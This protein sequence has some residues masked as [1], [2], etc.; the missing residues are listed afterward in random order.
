MATD[1]QQKLLNAITQA[2]GQLYLVGGAVRDQLLG[3]V[4]KDND[5][6]VTGLNIETVQNTLANFARVDAV[7]KSFGVLKVTLNDETVDVALPRT[8]QSTGLHHRDFDITSDAHLPIEADL[9]RR[10]FT[11]NAMALR[12]H[13]QVLIDPFFGKRDLQLRTLRAVGNVVQRFS[14]DPLRMLR[15]ARFVAKLDFEIETGTLNAIA[16]QAPEIISVAAERIG[17]ELLGLLSASQQDSGQNI[18]RALRVLRDTGLMAWVIPEYRVCIAYDQKNPHHHLSLDE[19]MFEVVRQVSLHSSDPEVK[20]PGVNMAATTMAALLHDIAKPQTQTFGPDG[21]AHYHRHEQHGAAMARVICERLKFSTEL[22]NTVAKLVANH[23][24]PPKDASARTLRRYI[25]NLGQEWQS[26]LCLRASDM[27]SHTPTESFE[28][29]DWFWHTLSTCKNFEQELERFNERELN[30]SGQELMQAFS[31]TPGPALGE[32]KKRAT[33]AVI[34]G[35]IPNL[36]AEILAWLR[37][38]N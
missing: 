11:V 14:E 25:N 12:L 30:I 15:A 22:T 1:L 13:D 23:M 2:G 32:L 35:E 7:G 5:Y 17:Y 36:A 8:E 37:A 31:L 18:V 26:A 4:C 9:A 19:H 29:W 16:K 33:Q 27:A 20:M 6:L 10:D 3:L 28:A 24:R 21:V 38:N 34:D